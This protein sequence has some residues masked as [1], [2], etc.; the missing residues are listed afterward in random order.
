MAGVVQYFRLRY[1]PY[2]PLKTPL[3]SKF[4]ACCT[5]AFS[6]VLSLSASFAQSIYISE[7]MASNQ[8]TIDDED[9]DSSDWIELFNASAS[10]V[11][12]D[13]WYL[14]DDPANLTMW[15][16]PGVTLGSGQFLLVF[17]S[18]KNRRDPAAE[19]HTNFK[20][21]S[22]GD[23]IALVQSDGVT[24]EHDYAPSYPAQITDV[25]YGLG[26]S[27]ANSTLLTLG[28]A[29]KW[30]VP[31]N[32]ND[33]VDNG[34]NPNPWIGTN[35]NDSAWGSGTAGAGYAEAN[36]DAYDAFIQTDLETQLNNVHPTL[37]LRI[38]FTVANPAAV[39]GLTL[40]MRYDD[41]FVAYISGQPEP[42]A[43]QNA[44]ADAVLDWES[45]ATADHPDSASVQYED[46]TVDTSPL[47]A[48][49]NVL[50][51]HALNRSTGSSD[52]LAQPELVATGSAALNGQTNYSVNAS[53]GS[54]NVLT[55]NP[56]PLIADITDE[57]PAINV[58]GGGAISVPITAVVTPTLNPVSSV[59]LAYRVMYGA[60]I[61]VPMVDNGIGNDAVAG[62][63]IY[64]ATITTSAL[65]AGEML[66]W[67]IEADD[68]LANTSKAPAFPDPLDSP[69]YFG[70]IA[71]DPSVNTS[72]LPVIHWFTDDP[73]GTTQVA[74]AR[75]SIYFE[76][77]FY[78]N[79]L[80][81]RHGQSTGGFPKKSYDFD[82]NA[83]DRFRWKA[84]E[85]R[86]KD[87]NLLTNWADK[88]KVRNTLG[89]GLPGLTGEPVH[90][91]QMVRVQ[92]NAA[93]FNTA[94]MVED[95]DDR[96]LDRV[97][98]DDN[99]ALY[100]MYNRLDSTSGATK[101]T[102]KEESSADIQALITGLGQSGDA[103]LRYGYDHVD[104]PGTVN[105][106]TCLTLINNR[107]HGHKNYYM[108]RDTEGTEEWRP[109]IW[110]V[111]LN[112]GR[113]WV[114]G[115][116]YFDDTFTVNDVENGPTNRLKDL[117][118]DDPELRGMFL[119]RLKTIADTVIQPA[120]TPSP[121]IDTWVDDLVALVDPSGVVSDADLDYTKWGSWGNN[122]NVQ[123]AAARIKNEYLPAARADW[124]GSA[125]STIGG[126][127]PTSQPA[128][129]PVDIVM[130]EFNPPSGNQQEEYFMLSHS[131][132]YDVDI[133][134]WSIDDGVTIDI[135]AGTV[136]PPGM[137][138]Y[139][140][141]DAVSFRAR[142]TSPKADEKR[143]LI[144]GYGGQLSARGETLSLYD[145]QLNLID[146]LTYTGAPTAVQQ[147]LRITELHYHPADPTAAELA[148]DSDWTA[149]DF[150]FIELTNTGSSV[151]DISG[152]QFVTGINFVFPAG[153]SLAGGQSVLVVGNQAA[154][155]ARY[156]TAL[157]VAG[158]YSGQLDNGGEEMQLLDGVGENVQ[159]FTFDDLWYVPTDGSGYSMEIRDNNSPY[160][161][162]DLASAWAPSCLIHGSPG[163]TGLPHGMLYGIWK[164]SS[165]S[166]ADAANPA[167]SGPNV[168]LD[169]DSYPNMLEY[170]FGSDPAAVEPDTWTDLGA[171]SIGAADYLTVSFTR[172][173]HAVDLV[174]TVEVGSDLSGWA[175]VSIPV[176]TPV[177]NPDGT[178]TVTFRD[179]QPIA[180]GVRHFIRVSVLLNE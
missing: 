110:D 21:S 170:A 126:K 10:P 42:V 138:L 102:R 17:A 122:N 99:G 113:N 57:Y 164:E 45:T 25:S 127:L 29:L 140:G 74:G 11:D 169:G 175:P 179:S 43:S 130:G 81:D 50:C 116:A 98:L 90:F 72:L 75:S 106:L 104:I 60:E 124:F 97:G 119:R 16:I 40:R 137:T 67:R 108:Y 117:I 128:M 35:F 93:F 176:G 63:D 23:Y 132:S 112:L 37:Y 38:P 159:E 44:P 34:N 141:R 84:G 15:E 171:A 68:T 149:S 143:F 162:W 69:E 54:I 76:G 48:G 87:I 107:D 92:Q 174:Y 56:G 105:Y 6:V 27:G 71:L 39:S 9:G 155:E 125:S 19:L 80:T 4:T 51:I 86:V 158:E 133:S 52:L 114:S 88:A 156:G 129:A 94:D 100:K 66:R 135:P 118:Y 167:V 160:T 168:D 120:G 79:I 65:S 83:G 134:G 41:G 13:G 152:A 3:M 22:S 47:V 123:Q 111:D 12:L 5:A 26:M 144:S 161:D 91:V 180:S 82:F 151:L 101:K 121:V 163:Q 53:P 136:I 7:F 165:F 61:D 46:F 62:D 178:E 1:S 28:S 20:L 115:P 33:D 14:T 85:R 166:A 36:P 24:I 8:D 103:K 49:A 2:P 145:D 77:E 89:Y 109:L 172:H 55:G 70:T 95:G 139:V 73:V 32:G 78:D 58:S 30:R 150:E 146:T 96:Y 157:N 147:W 142:A 18:D 154:F 131:N 177:S 31:T 59:T 153:T 173:P 148:I 64:T